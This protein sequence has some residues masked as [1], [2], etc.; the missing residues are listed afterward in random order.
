MNLETLIAL[1]DSHLKI[2]RK[3]L[4]WKKSLQCGWPRDFEPSIDSFAHRKQRMSIEHGCLVWEDKVVILPSLRQ[5]SFERFPWNS[6]RGYLI[7]MSLD[8]VTYASHACIRTLRNL[9][10]VVKHANL[11]RLCFRKP[12]YIIRKELIISGPD[13]I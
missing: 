7:W 5:K 8:V 3:N 13:I 2:K 11:I 12:Q 4:H 9:L 6:P 10:T 1:A